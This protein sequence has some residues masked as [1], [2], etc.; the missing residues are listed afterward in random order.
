MCHRQNGAL[1]DTFLRGCLVRGCLVARVGSA[2]VASVM[3]D[4]V[5]REQHPEK[6]DMVE[7]ET[8][9]WREHVLSMAQAGI[10]NQ[11]NRIEE[12][13]TVVADLA[14]DIVPCI[15]VADFHIRPAV[16][17]DRTRCC[18]LAARNSRHGDGDG[19]AAAAVDAVDSLLPFALAVDYARDWSLWGRTR[20][21]DDIH[22]LRER[23]ASVIWCSILHERLA[24]L[25]VVWA[26][27]AGRL[28]CHL[29]DD[30]RKDEAEESCHRRRL[31]P[32]DHM[33]D[34]SLRVWIHL[35]LE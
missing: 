35:C 29:A 23:L 25:L 3:K 5:H 19:A 8:P 2:R 21:D 7:D 30:L 16:S 15:P 14:V 10:Q 20:I 13:R 12:G 9:M 11:R 32:V 34:E 27:E 31:L 1:L 22:R 4:T 17:P 33:D 28:H 6:E 24:V 26:R 18:M